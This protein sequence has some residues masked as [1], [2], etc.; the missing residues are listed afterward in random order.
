MRGSQTRSSSAP[1][2]SELRSEEGDAGRARP[3]ADTGWIAAAFAIAVVAV[4]ARFVLLRATHSATEDFFITLRFAE[5]IARGRGFVYNPGER[6][7][8]T[9][10]PLYTLALALASRIGANPILAGKS[11]NILADGV[12]VYLIAAIARLLGR[13]RVGLLAALLYAFASTPVNFSIGGMETGLV[14]LAV[15]GAIYSFVADR[16][17]A[18][19]VWLA[20]LFLLRIDGLLLAVLLAAGWLLR[21]RT[22]IKA[23]IRTLATAAWPGLLLAAPWPIF[24]WLYFGS[25][26][27]V[28]IV[29]KLAVYGRMVPERMPNL[30][31]FVTQFWAGLPQKALLI[32]FV[33]GAARHLRDGRL[34]APLVWLFVYYGAMLVSKV[35]AFGWYFMPPLPLYYLVA[36]LGVGWVWTWCTKPL[37]KPARLEG[38]VLSGIAILTLALVWH[39]RSIERDIAKAQRTEDDVRLPIG[40][41]LRDNARPADRVLLEPI[42]YIGYYSRLPVLD[43]IGLVSPEVLP[44]YRA[45]VDNPRLDIV[46]R[47]RPDLLLL[48]PSEAKEIGGESGARGGPLAGGE[49]TLEHT[50]RDEDGRGITFLLFR[51]RK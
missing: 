14:T 4:I 19:F 32:G 41:W 16:P 10:T 8:G 2:F 26:V 37:G 33:A 18:M 23:R 49:Y 40:L 46:R 21:Q 30:D 12:T 22:P 39:L 38:A 24:A 29:A 36:A 28:S 20:F 5:N 7:L 25:P 6:V 42:G 51:K 17:R 43:M 47:L 11:A 35:P 9:T 15:A 44:S 45:S 50:F 1:R 48:R 31:A 3:R 34:A 13:P 27:P